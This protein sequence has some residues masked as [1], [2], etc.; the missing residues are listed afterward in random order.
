MSG[1]KTTGLPRFTTSLRTKGE[2]VC[3]ILYEPSSTSIDLEC[4]KKKRA[5]KKTRGRTV[6]ELVQLVSSDCSSQDKQKV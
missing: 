2:S 5:R 6:A 1:R 3:R 4:L